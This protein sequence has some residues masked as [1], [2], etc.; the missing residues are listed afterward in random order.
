MLIFI[1]VGVLSANLKR[2]PPQKVRGFVRVN[3][4]LVPANQCV[5]KFDS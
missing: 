4:N 3:L 2:M 5:R 1:Y